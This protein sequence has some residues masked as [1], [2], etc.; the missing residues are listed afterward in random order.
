M[1]ELRFEAIHHFG[2]GGGGCRWR[3]YLIASRPGMPRETLSR[4]LGVVAR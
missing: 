2:D 1:P 3:Q 4:S